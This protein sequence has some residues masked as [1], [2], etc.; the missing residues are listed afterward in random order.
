MKTTKQKILGFH[1]IVFPNYLPIVETSN[2]ILPI[3]RRGKILTRKN[4]ANEV[5]YKRLSRKTASEN[6]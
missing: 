6:L 5:A 4:G 2:L 3:L 1:K